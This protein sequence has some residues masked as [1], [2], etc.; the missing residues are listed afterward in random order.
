MDHRRQLDILDPRLFQYPITLIGCGGIGSPT[1]ILLAKVGCPNLTIIDP[2]EVEAHNLPNQFF[3]LSAA[4]KPKVF[5]LRDAIGEFSDCC[6]VT[7]VPEAFASHHSLSGIVIS[8]VDTMKTRNEIWSK[9]RWNTAVPLFLDG[10]LGGEVLQVYT[11]K[12]CQLE[13]TELY[14]NN[15]F[16]D[17]EAAELPCTARAV[18]YVGFAIA[19][20]IVAQLKK[21]LKGESYHRI[22]SFDFPTMT[23]L[24]Q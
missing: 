12:P 19:A 23:L 22:V 6:K 9:V 3:P 20:V 13:D 1:A 2:D 4:G 8:G 15:L 16:P 5:A 18:M 24:L 21:W 14:E 10:R 7:A 11:I 17:E